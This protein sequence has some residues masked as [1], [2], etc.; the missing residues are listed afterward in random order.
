MEAGLAKLF[1]SEVAM[2][3]ALTALGLDPPIQ[4]ESSGK[5]R[6]DENLRFLTVGNVGRVFE[7]EN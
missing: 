4:K 7:S 2:K 5:P 1:A 3:V 6:L